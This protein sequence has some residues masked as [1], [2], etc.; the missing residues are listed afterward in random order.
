MSLSNIGTHTLKA[1]QCGIEPSVV[2]AFDD[3]LKL[4]L[5]H[6]FDDLEDTWRSF[7][8]T[9]L[10]TAFQNFDWLNNWFSHAGRHLNW[11]PCLLHGTARN[12]DTIFILPLGYYSIGGQRILSWLGDSHSTYRMGLF[13]RQWITRQSPDTIRELLKQIRKLLPP[14]DVIHLGAQPSSWEEIANPFAAINALPTAS[15][16]HAIKLQ[17]DFEALYAS[18]RTASTIKKARKRERSFNRRYP[19][20]FHTA[21]SVQELAPVMEE[22]IRQK[23]V[24]LKD[25]GVYDFMSDPGIRD[26]FKA[27]AL[28]GLDGETH[29]LRVFYMKA[30]DH[31]AATWMGLVQRSRIYGLMNTMTDDPDI[32]R[33]SPGEVVLRYAISECCKDGL[34]S[35]DLAVGESRYK[36]EW[37]DQHLALFETTLPV[38]VKGHI[39][40]YAARLGLRAKRLIKRSHSLW[41]LLLKLRCTCLPPLRGPSRR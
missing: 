35:F 11:T 29:Q 41:P 37:C 1:H 3:G 32:R 20:S 5:A 4:S 14:I 26:F 34:D 33:Y 31:I 22:L 39:Y 16:S 28:A 27:C 36:S 7:E 13:D 17:P 9:A 6:N 24:R 18:K 12:G 25:M 30:G 8:K 15:A 10:C 21:A 38:T 2:L 19:L 40:V 23:S